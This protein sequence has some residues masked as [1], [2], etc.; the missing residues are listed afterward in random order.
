MVNADHV[1]L[2]LPS[3]VNYNPIYLRNA[4][5]DLMTRPPR[6]EKS[7][8]STE[9]SI[10]TS[11]EVVAVKA[12]KFKPVEANI[13]HLADHYKKLVKARADIKQM[14]AY[15]DALET[16]IK[17]ELAALGAT[18]G[19][20][21]GAVVV[22]HRPKEAYRLAEFRADYAEVYDKYL[23]PMETFVLDEDALI[24]NHRGL[25]EA[26]RSTAFNVK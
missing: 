24:A 12:E 21:K 3:N 16:M 26:Y 6:Q 25:L 15:K 19:K 1:P 17:H 18:D 14:I 11:A 13:D 22:T 10:P 20:I 23:V 2:R 8:M 7:T 5:V 4:M 9:V